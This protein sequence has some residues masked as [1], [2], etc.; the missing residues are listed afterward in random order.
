[1]ADNPTPPQPLHRHPLTAAELFLWSTDC[2]KGSR[3]PTTQT[4]RRHL[5]KLIA[6][7]QLTKLISARS[8]ATICKRS[9]ISK[10]GWTD[11]RKPDD[12]RMHNSGAFAAA[13]DNRKRSL[14]SP[15]LSQFLTSNRPLELSRQ[16]H[17]LEWGSCISVSYP[18]NHSPSRSQSR[19]AFT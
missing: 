8:M 19:V 4:T 11:H 1:M 17:A 15:T 7:W 14:R 16:I 5:K 13:R 6:I 12:F 18:S 9:P 2:T 3:K 10:S